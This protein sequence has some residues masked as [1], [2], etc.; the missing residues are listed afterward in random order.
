MTSVSV[1]IIK[2]MIVSFGSLPL[3]QSR[4]NGLDLPM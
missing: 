3:I 4:E 1:S 2:G